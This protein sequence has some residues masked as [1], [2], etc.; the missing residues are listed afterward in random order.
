MDILLS[1]NN[2]T[3]TYTGHTALDNVSIVARS[4]ASS[5][6]MVQVRPLLSVSSIISL[7]PTKA[8]LHSMVTPSPLKMFTTSVTS[9]RSV[10]STRR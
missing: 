3:K 8:H 1:A 6:L 2:I 10:A 7:P 5:A 4:M 9:R